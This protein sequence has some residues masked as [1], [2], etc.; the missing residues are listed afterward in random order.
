MTGYLPLDPAFTLNVLEP[1]AAL[2]AE[3]EAAVEAIWSRE[4][5]RAGCRLFNGPVLSLAAKAPDCLTVRRADYRHL[6]AQRLQ[7]ELGAWLKLRPLAVTGVL[8]C[9]EGVVFGR[10]ALHLANAPGAWEPAPSGGLSHPD[11]RRQ[12]LEELSEELGLAA[13]QVSPPQ[14]FGLIWEDDGG[15]HDI[16]F[17]L[18][19]EA[20]A[21]DLLTA[22][23]SAGS[24]EYSELAI[25]PPQRLGAF[26]AAHHDTLLPIARR[27]LVSAMPAAFK[28]C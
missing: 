11:P 27:I 26:L 18:T 6:I 13:S 3:I 17:R 25:V 7:P 10:R 1:S 9:R 19:T 20:T 15:V 12:L 16:L 8:T 21:K 22:H 2:P 24:D 28:A 23:Q 14:A 5:S 4:R